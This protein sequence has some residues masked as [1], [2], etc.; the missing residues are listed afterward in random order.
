MPVERCDAA[1]RCVSTREARTK[2]DTNHTSR[3]RASLY[4]KGIR[5]TDDG[6]ALAHR[7][8]PPSILSQRHSGDE[9]ASASARIVLTV[10]FRSRASVMRLPNAAP[11]SADTRT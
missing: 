10:K 11:L 3:R 1:S 2:Q 9:S 7:L 8:G 6:A 5:S 4:R